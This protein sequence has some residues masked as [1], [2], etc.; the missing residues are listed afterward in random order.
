LHGRES[1]ARVFDNLNSYAATVHFNGQSTV[2]A[3]GRWRQRLNGK[4]ARMRACPSLSRRRRA[5]D[6][7]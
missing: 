4:Y 6:E 3:V 7:P 5:N 2:G 1:L